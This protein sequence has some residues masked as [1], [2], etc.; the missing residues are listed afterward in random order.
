[1]QLFETVKE[2][3]VQRGPVVVRER[4]RLHRGERGEEEEGRSRELAVSSREKLSQPCD[5]VS[6]RSCPAVNLGFA[7]AELGH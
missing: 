1:M 5:I 2:K 3:G 7:E 4:Q 6:A